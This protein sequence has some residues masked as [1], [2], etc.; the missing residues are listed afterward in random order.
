M[1]DPGENV[2]PRALD[3]G[4]TTGRCHVREA[5]RGDRSDPN[6][7]GDPH[8]SDNP[9]ATAA[10][11]GPGMFAALVAVVVASAAAVAAEVLVVEAEMMFAALVVA[12]AVVVAVGHFRDKAPVRV[13]ERSRHRLGR[14]RRRFGGNCHGRRP[15][16]SVE[17]E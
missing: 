12:A 9:V 10:E 2:H 17:P 13:K 4:R 11:A 6:N 8:R 7:C 3:R 16:H 15:G 1:H 14:C 5:P